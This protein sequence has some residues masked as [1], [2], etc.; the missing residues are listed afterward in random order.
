MGRRSLEAI[1][2]EIDARSS[3]IRW[4]RTECEKHKQAVRE[5]QRERK[6]RLSRLSAA[7]AAEERDH[8]SA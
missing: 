4:L 3:E 2:E 6:K 7:P 1:E 5:L 8:G